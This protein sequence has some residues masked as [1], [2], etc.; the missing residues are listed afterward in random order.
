MNDA[1]EIC[2]NTKTGKTLKVWFN[3]AINLLVVDIIDA[4]DRG[5]VELVRQTIPDNHTVAKAETNAQ[6]GF[7]KTYRMTPA[8]W[9]EK[10]GVQVLDPDGW[11]NDG[12]K[13]K[14]SWEIPIPWDMFL[15]RFNDST[16]RIV[17]K[18]KYLLYKHLFS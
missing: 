10:T 9:C 6:R 13:F 7:T 3:P 14:I 4:D 15:S 12:N 5:G 16:T 11:R 18:E 2:W 17:D 1:K 8:Q